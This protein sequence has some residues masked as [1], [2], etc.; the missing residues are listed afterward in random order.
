MGRPRHRYS[1]SGQRR[2]SGHV[3]GVIRAPGSS[4]EEGATIREGGW[5]WSAGSWNAVVGLLL[6][7]TALGLMMAILSRRRSL[8]R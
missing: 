4:Y 5:F 8:T 2:L 7:L 3:L 1:A 6:T